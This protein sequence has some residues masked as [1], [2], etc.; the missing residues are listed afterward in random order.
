MVKQNTDCNSLGVRF[1]YSNHLPIVAR[2]IRCIAPNAIMLR[3]AGE[4]GN[5]QPLGSLITSSHVGSESATSTYATMSRAADSP[6]VPVKPVMR[7]LRVIWL[8]IPIK[9]LAL[10]NERVQ[11]LLIQLVVY[12]DK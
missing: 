1:K 3:A 5:L 4:L 11:R 7:A 8:R 6:I 12:H 2:S 9:L 10:C